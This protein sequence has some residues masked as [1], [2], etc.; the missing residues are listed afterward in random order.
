MEIDVT[1]MVD[2]S[3]E[4]PLLS[5]SVAELGQN[6]GPF[7]WNNSKDYGKAHPLLKTEDD[8]DE[9]RRWLKE[10]GAWSED[11]IAAWG[12]DDLQGIICQ[13]IAGDIR[14]MEVAEDYEDYQ[15][16][17]EAGTVSGNLYRGDDE[18]WYFYLGN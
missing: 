8:R 16:L 18:R 5:G 6:A 9:A 7:T 15:R 12:E 1:H 17:A 3:D 2:D 14:E 4:M 10:F 11:E 13:F